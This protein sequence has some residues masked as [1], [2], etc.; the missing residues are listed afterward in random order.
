ME[1]EFGEELSPTGV[2][3]FTTI[4]IVLLVFGIP[5]NVLF[6]WTLLKIKRLRVIHNTFVGNLAVA[7]FLITTY[8]LP[9]NLLFLLNKEVRL[10]DNLCHINGV[11]THLFFSSSVMSVSII[12]ANRY[13]KIC[14]YNLCLR[15]FTKTSVSV[16]IAAV[17]VTGSLFALPLFWMKQS[18]IFD[19]TL[20]M[21][22]FNRYVSQTYSIV[23]LFVCLFTPVGITVICYCKIYI[24]VQRHK[25]RLLAW[26]NGIG[27]TRFRSDLRAT[28]SAFVVFVFYLVTYSLFGVVATFFKNH[29][30]VSVEIHAV[31]IYMCYANSCVNTLIY[32]VLN[33]EV[34][35]AY[36]EATFCCRSRQIQ[37]IQPDC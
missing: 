5:S 13:V 6:L 27:Q 28:K 23:F 17:W 35:K 34:L 14:H 22:I 4:A 19:P 30:E 7:D 16:I 11:L 18:L 36:K 12:A 21:C 9:F 10:P 2:V 24:Y 8:L 1:L 33:K 25:K 32:G 31:S 29:S 20:Q 26:N 3:V 37:D 15:I